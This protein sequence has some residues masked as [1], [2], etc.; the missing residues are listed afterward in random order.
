MSLIL[1]DS[2]RRRQRLRYDQRSTKNT[3]PR[4]FH[5][6]RGFYVFGDVFWKACHLLNDAGTV[7]LICWG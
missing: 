2:V 1:E 3:A 6:F 7:N 5:L 4:M